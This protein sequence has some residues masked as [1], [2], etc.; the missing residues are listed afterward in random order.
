[1]SLNRRSRHLLAT[2]TTKIEIQ[3]IQVRANPEPYLDAASKQ[4]FEL[5]R[6]LDEIELSLRPSMSCAVI[7]FAEAH[8]M[9]PIDVVGEGLIRAN[10]AL[11]L[12]DKYKQD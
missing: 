4:I 10:A 8:D 3:R 6:L 7:D 5:R 12:I 2:L 1:M 11:D 9:K